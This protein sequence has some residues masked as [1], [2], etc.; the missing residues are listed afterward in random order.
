MLWFLDCLPQMI[1]C[2][3]VLSFSSKLSTPSTVMPWCVPCT[4]MKCRVTLS[5]WLT[6]IWSGE[7]VNDLKSQAPTLFGS[8]IL[9]PPPTGMIEFTRLL[10][11]VQRSVLR[12]RITFYTKIQVCV[13]VKVYC[14]YPEFFV[15]R[16]VWIDHFVCRGIFCE[17]F[18]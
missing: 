3:I 7:K 6:T 16:L 9:K 8:V 18:L 5:P 13:S 14:I 17:R 11:W 10:S 4:P 2:V 15:C 12:T 1:Q